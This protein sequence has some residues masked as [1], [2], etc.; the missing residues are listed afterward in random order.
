VHEIDDPIRFLEVGGN[1]R[2]EFDLDRLDASIVQH[3]IELAADPAVAVG[4]RAC[5]EDSSHERA[6]RKVYRVGPPIWLQ[7]DDAAAGS[8]NPHHL[9]HGRLGIREVLQHALDADAIER[10]IRQGEFMGVFFKEV[11]VRRRALG[12]CSA[13]HLWVVIN[14]NHSSGRA[15]N[16]SEREDVVSEATA[17][18]K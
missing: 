9:A 13:Q 6:V 8:K 18:I 14:A 10:C 3:P 7:D 15:N 4:V 5:V 2:Y 11:D 17:E 1:E 12:A 16:L